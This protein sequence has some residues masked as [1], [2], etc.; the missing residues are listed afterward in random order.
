[1]KNC[2]NTKITDSNAP[3]PLAEKN[4]GTLEVPMHDALLVQVLESQEGL[5]QSREDHGLG[6]H[7]LRHLRL[8]DD[9]AEIPILCQ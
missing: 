2:R 6:K 1:M 4:V 7:P 3:P 5:P 8:P 9:A